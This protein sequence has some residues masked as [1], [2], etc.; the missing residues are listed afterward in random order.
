MKKTLHT[1]AIVVTLVL[2]LAIPTFATASTPVAGEIHGTGLVGGPPTFTPAGKGNT[3]IVEGTALYEWTGNL[4]G[5]SV[6][7]FVSIMHGPCFREDG[8]PY[9]AG[10]FRENL[11]FTGTFEGTVNDSEWGTFDYAQPFKF[12]PLPGGTLEEPNYKGRGKAAIQNGT[13]GLAGLHGVLTFAGGRIDGV[14]ESNY[15]G[16]IHFDPSP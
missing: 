8:T 13:S 3:C 11:K 10:T 9:P 12:V 1:L 15:Q 16:E 4:S 7:H 5:T 6:E 14:E 2:A